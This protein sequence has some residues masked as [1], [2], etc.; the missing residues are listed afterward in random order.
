[1]TGARTIV[2]GVDGSTQSEAALRWALIEA[3]PGDRVRAVL[4]RARDDLLPGTSYAIQPHGRTP[5][6]VDEEYAERLRTTVA[7][8]AGAD[9]SRVEQVVRTGDPAAELIAESAAA[10]F[11]ALG[12]HGARPVTELLLGRVTARC[13]RHARCPVVVM[14][15]GAR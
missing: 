13:V 2:V 7:A 12:S 9:A 3:G 6:G 14:P 15:P 11:L 10:A 1:M 8:A 5:V 4:V